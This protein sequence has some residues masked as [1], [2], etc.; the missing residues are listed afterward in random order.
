MKF[1]VTNKTT[2]IDLGSYTI[3][4]FSNKFGSN[5]CQLRKAVRSGYTLKIG[6]TIFEF[7]NVR[8]VYGKKISTIDLLEK[9]INQLKRKEKKVDANIN[10]LLNERISNYENII[11][12]TNEL[13]IEIQTKIN[14]Q[15]LD[16]KE[17][18]SITNDKMKLSA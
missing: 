8:E 12:L 9:Q 6:N 7:S 11:L 3:Q 2:G 10:K 16:H 1:D 13:I 18:K 15:K 17:T 14:V 5:K 4:E